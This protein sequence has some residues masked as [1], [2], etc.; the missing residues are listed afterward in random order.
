MGNKETL[1]R[2]ISEQGYKRNS[3]DKNRPFNIIPSNNITMKGVDFPVLG[4]DNL[5]NQQLMQPGKDYIFPGN[6][7]FEI[8]V[9]KQFGGDMKFWRPVLQTGGQN[10]FT[11]SG[12][13]VVIPSQGSYPLEYRDRGDKDVD[14]IPF[15][16]ARKVSRT[17]P[18]GN[19]LT[20]N[21]VAE[22]QLMWNM[23]KQAYSPE[24]Q[25]FNIWKNNPENTAQ[26][27][28]NM[29]DWEKYLKSITPTGE[30]VP[31]EGL[32]TGKANKRGKTK[33]SCS[34]GQSNKGECLSDNKQFG[35]IMFKFP[36]MVDYEQP[37]N[38]LIN[39]DYDMERA[40][41]LGYTPDET[42]HWPSVDYETGEWLKSKKHHTRGMELMA[43]ELNP[44]LHNAYNLIEN[45]KGKM[46][47][48]PKG[49]NGIEGTMGGLTNKGFNYN[50]A[51]GGQFQMGGFLK[52]KPIYVDSPNDPRYIAYQDSLSL[53]KGTK[54]VNDFIKKNNIARFK[55]DNDKPLSKD[56]KKY[57]KIKKTT[58]NKN[59]VPLDILKKRGN[60]SI[61]P[62]I[63]PIS[64]DKY[65][66]TI[67]KK[68]SFF[69][70]PSD[71]LIYENTILA[72][73]KKPQQE[74]II[75][76]TTPPPPLPPHIVKTQKSKLPKEV[77]E[78]TQKEFDRINAKSP[79]VKVGKDNFYSNDSGDKVVIKEK[80]FEP[81]QTQENINITSQGLAQ[82]NTELIPNLNII[83]QA[84]TPK[85]FKVTD[86]VNQPFGGTETNYQVYPDQ[87]FPSMSTQTYSDGTPMNIRQVVPVYQVGGIWM[88]NKLNSQGYITS[89]TKG[90]NRITFT[91][92]Q[93]ADDWIN[94][95]I[96]SGK[97]GFDPT[98]GGTFPLKK[99][100]KGLSKKDQMMA[101]REYG[102]LT[103]G[104]GFT[105]DEQELKIKSLPKEQQELINQANR[106]K[107]EKYVA[108]SMQE[109]YQ[110]PLMS[111][112]VFTPEG[113]AIGAIQGFVNMGPDLYEGNYLGAAG[114]LLMTLPVTGRYIGQG[115]KTAGRAISKTKNSIFKN[116]NKIIHYLDD[117]D[118]I[119]NPFDVVDPSHPTLD[120]G[121]LEK[122]KNKH[123]NKFESLYGKT[124]DEK[125]LGAF[126]KLQEINDTRLKIS[127]K[128]LNY[129]FQNEIS[130]SFIKTHNLNTELTPAEKLIVDFYQHGYDANLNARPGFKNHLRKFYDPISENLE[131]IITRAKTKKPE[132]FWRN[133]DDFQLPKAWDD[134]GVELQNIFLSDLKPGFTYEPQSFISTS[135]NPLPTFGS[136][137]SK[138]NVPENQSFFFPNSQGYNMFYNELENILPSKLKFRIDDILE[139]GTVVK[140]I[141]NPYLKG[142]LIKA[143][144]GKNIRIQNADGTI[145]TINTSSPE[146]R[147]MYKSGM[148]QHPF[149]GQG[150]NPYWGG[151]LDEVSVTRAPREK[152]FWEKY[153]DK[154]VE[155]NRDAGFFGAI[156]GTPI[157]AVTSLPQLAAT[158][159]LT[160]KMQR[161]SEALDI[162]NPYGAFAVDAV[163][164]P[165]NW[166]GG[167]LLDDATNFTGKAR[168][169]FKKGFK[170]PFKS[171]IDWGKWNPETPKYPELINEYNAIEESTKKA[172]TWMKNPDGSPFQGTPEQFIQQQSSWFKKAF[173]NSKLVNPDGSPTIQYHGS[174]KKFD[175]FDESKFQLGD[176][177]YSGR[178]I[179]TTPSKN[180][181]ESYALSSKIIHKD[182]NYE[183]TVYE[184]YGRGNNPISAEDLIKQKK[185]YDLFNFHRQKDWRG[186]V[187]L[188]EQ[189]LDYDVAIRNQTK[190]IERIAP[191]HEANELV[192]PTNKSVKSAVGNVGFFDMTNPNIYKSVLPIGLGLGAASQMQQEPVTGMQKGGV[193]NNIAKKK[194]K[195]Q[196]IYGWMTS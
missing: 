93:R 168:N 19:L 108:S 81:R 21:Q 59:N 102:E 185:E 121:D 44:E 125:D 136:I 98:T 117:V 189:L 53:Y 42:G 143:Q 29:S 18:Q 106:N 150:N 4:I 123:R 82:T 119:E 92:D 14:G 22:N 95:Q 47:Y 101:T 196:N 77:R 107:R 192:F 26:G 91:G 25:T 75:K 30:N 170:K 162:Q 38:E 46:Q 51:W 74:V 61:N 27:F 84:K 181:A 145:S 80:T 23:Q 3:P 43:Y 161:P 152:G 180:K 66:A 182:G 58:Y 96:D 7:V 194:A 141:V 109:A 36:S 187:P 112:G 87:D 12:N 118:E 184:L 135:L 69:G 104:S 159:A 132:V 94:K 67:P 71:E 45:E 193:I 120:F 79:L 49:K 155:E 105:T 40:L 37:S 157:S 83:Q 57:L 113:A 50:G 186:D 179:Y 65:V 140:S 175:T 9:R 128:N 54:S 63:K 130:S 137:R 164:D 20:R 64:Y 8:P 56:E 99:P 151:L 173:G 171:E 70:V 176:S 85:Y 5:G 149:A 126:A 131:S 134:K 172:G 190:G 169:L 148:V 89:E 158:Y 100:V 76:N 156:I 97:F 166:F 10:P 13:P 114:D 73:Y 103:R 178:G 138:I 111:P 110:H 129:P 191:W 88:G 41:E 174:A 2:F 48:I 127:D 16:A 33:G 62:N 35:G 15:S 72:N 188:E 11:V 31:L 116:N 195:H 133:E 147:A 167:G 177:G 6:S 165:A 115:F 90:G 142:G 17:D 78:V 68:F 1:L 60:N 24:Q 154:I 34:T 160:D 124:Y 55:K 28:Y 39:D 144:E 146:Y 163:A 86:K 52:V 122:L 153:R 32:E 183:P 139:D